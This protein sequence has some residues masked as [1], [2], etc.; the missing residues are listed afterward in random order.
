MA[1]GII[2]YY[3]LPTT[4]LEGSAFPACGINPEDF[5][6]LLLEAMSYFVHSRMKLQ[7]RHLQV[8]V[9]YLH[10]ALVMAGLLRTVC[11]KH[12]WFCSGFVFWSKEWSRT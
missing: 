3:L 4:V 9:G 12:A 8:W 10:C 5:H 6:F 7:I 2:L 11:N 1:K